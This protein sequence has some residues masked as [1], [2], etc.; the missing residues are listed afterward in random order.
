MGV[1]SKEVARVAERRRVR[2]RSV[3]LVHGTSARRGW[4]YA[5]VVAYGETGYMLGDERP[6]R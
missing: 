2:P 3:L 1:V 4:R 5:T 6:P